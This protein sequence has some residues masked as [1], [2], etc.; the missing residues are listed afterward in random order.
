MRGM[1]GDWDS[2]WVSRGACALQSCE[3]VYCYTACRKY[4][5]SH[6][7]LYSSANRTACH[8]PVVLPLGD[9]VPGW[10]LC[11]RRRPSR[12]LG[13]WEAALGR[14]KVG[15]WDGRDNTVR[16]SCAWRRVGADLGQGTSQG[17]ARNPGTR[18]RR[19]ASNWCTPCRRRTRLGCP[20]MSDNK[21]SRNIPKRFIFYFLHILKVYQ[22]EVRTSNSHVVRFGYPI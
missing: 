10:T 19:A 1:S 6:A 20:E 9:L 7:S 15:S 14:G 8:I 3:L 12:P 4:T 21:G 16:Y 11:L 22:H 13:Y 18:T 5:Q 2:A 17:R